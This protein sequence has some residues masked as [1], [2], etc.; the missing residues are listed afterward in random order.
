MSASRA[1]TG[2]R[3][4]GSLGSAVAPMIDRRVIGKGSARCADQDAAERC[5]SVSRRVA[6]PHGLPRKGAARNTGV[7]RLRRLTVRYERRADI[8]EAFNRLAA[9]L[10]CL[11][12]VERWSCQALRHGA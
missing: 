4:S 10:I 3:G 5:V 1:A 9:A 8:L 12:F 6:R 11:G 7:A 2:N